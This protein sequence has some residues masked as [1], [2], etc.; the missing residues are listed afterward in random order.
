MEWTINLDQGIVSNK[1][2]DL[3][4]LMYEKRNDIGDIVYLFPAE[5][6]NL[7]HK[8]IKHATVIRPHFALCGYI[9]NFVTDSIVIFGRTEIEFLN[10]LDIDTRYQRIEALSNFEIPCVFFTNYGEYEID[11]KLIDV[12]LNKDIPVFG[13]KNKTPVLLFRLMDILDDVFCPK[14]MVHGSLVEVFSVGI[15][16]IGD[17]GIG[18][19]ELTMELVGRGHLFVADDI[20]LI[21]RKLGH[22]LLGYGNQSVKGWIEIRGAGFIDITKYF[23][24]NRFKPITEVE[25]VIFLYSEKN[26]KEKVISAMKGL[27]VEEMKAKG[28]EVNADE[29][30]FEEEQLLEE[31]KDV[32]DEKLVDAEMMIYKRILKFSRENRTYEGTYEGIILGRKVSINPI[33]ID[34]ARDISIIVEA[35]ASRYN[36]LKCQFEEPK[37]KLNIKILP[38]NYLFPPSFYKED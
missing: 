24:V 26:M 21:M 11:Q 15:L 27:R 10:Q 2:I 33:N 3:H 34:K 1:Q 9:N 25:H 18:K 4:S 12:F 37:E 5:S 13:F 29:L 19:S 14:T 30:N 6:I 38:E 31:F 20:V 23:G 28:I 16:I 8:Q 22:K 7:R 32:P 17:S 35:I 36:S